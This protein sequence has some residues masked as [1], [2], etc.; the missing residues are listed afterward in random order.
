[1]FF[2]FPSLCSRFTLEFKALVYI[3]ISLVKTLIVDPGI[4]ID[5][6]N[7]LYDK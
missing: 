7:N 5:K 3:N 6:T 2:D 1:M 4:K